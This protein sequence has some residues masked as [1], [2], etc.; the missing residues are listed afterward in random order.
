MGDRRGCDNDYYDD[1]DYCCKCKGDGWYDR[2]MQVLEERGGGKC[3]RRS[4]K[5]CRHRDKCKNSYKEPHYSYWSGPSYG[6]S[7]YSRRQDDTI[8]VPSP[9]V[10]T[11]EAS[12]AIIE[13]EDT[14]DKTVTNI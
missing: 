1:D 11:V 3:N 5:K 13:A 2:I 14:T 9:K 10:E 4:G 7:S 8:F 6:W 12:V